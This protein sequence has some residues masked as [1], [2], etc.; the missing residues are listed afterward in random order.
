[1]T[2]GRGSQPSDGIS[3]ERSKGINARDKEWLTGHNSEENAGKM[4]GTY[5]PAK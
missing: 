3:Q 2:V 5:F 1:M 4:I